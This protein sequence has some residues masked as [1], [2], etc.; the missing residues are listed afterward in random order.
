MKVNIYTHTTARGPKKKITGFGYVLECETAKGPATL[1]HIGHFENET[2]NRSELRA[3]VEALKQ[4]KR[5]CELEI[6]TTP[7]MAAVIETWLPSWEAH[8]WKNSRGEEIDLEYRE[9]KNLLKPHSVSLKTDAHS[10]TEWLKRE[11]EKE[12]KEGCLTN[13]GNLIRQKK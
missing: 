2:K 11:T 3:L 12:E 8:G 7:Y 6:Y 10:F 1:S 4:L 13:T 5:P 9:L